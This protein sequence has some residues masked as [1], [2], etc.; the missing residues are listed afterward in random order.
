[1][2]RFWKCP[3]SVSVETEGEESSEVSEE[4][5]AVIDIIKNKLSKMIGINPDLFSEMDCCP[6]QLVYQDWVQDLIRSTRLA[7]Q[8]NQNISSPD[9]SHLKLLLIDQLLISS[10]NSENYEW[11]Q[12]KKKMNAEQ[13]K[14]LEK[15]KTPDGTIIKD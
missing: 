12:S 10:N 5:K 4:K 6:K 13:D 2:K 11:N 7:K 1:M 8:L 9:T 3:C 15:W 14:M